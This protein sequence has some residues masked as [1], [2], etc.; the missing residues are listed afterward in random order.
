M[1]NPSSFAL[2]SCPNAPKTYSY[3][4]TNAY[5]KFGVMKCQ[6]V[7]IFQTAA[8]PAKTKTGSVTMLQSP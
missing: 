5:F 1:K 2:L 3:F 6:I 4:I 7:I 8:T